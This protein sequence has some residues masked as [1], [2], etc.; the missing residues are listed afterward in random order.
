MSRFRGSF[1]RNVVVL[2]IVSLFT[3]V[4]S[5]MIYPIIFIFLQGIGASMAVVGLVEGVAEATASILKVVSGRHSD[6]KGKRKI[7]AL[8]GYSLSS[9]A[10]PLLFL[11]GS[12]QWVLGARFLDRFGKGIRTSPRDAL[13]AESTPLESRGAAFGLHRTLDTIGA[14]VGPL[15]ALALIY[16]LE[17]RYREI[18]L[19]SA[20]PAT[21]AVILLT[22]FVKE[23]PVKP[24]KNFKFNLKSLNPVYRRFLIVSFVFSLGNFTTA[25]P[26]LRARDIFEANHTQILRLTD[27]FPP[28]SDI[29]ALTL[30]I[31]VVYNITYAAAS[32]PAG[33]LSDRIGRKNIL[34]LGYLI[35]SA[36][37]LGFAFLSRG[38]S[39]WLLFAV[40]G[41]Y[42]G[43]TD[44][45]SKAFVVDLMP[46]VKATALGVYYTLTGLTMLAAGII[47]GL[48]WDFYG[49]DMAFLY[50]ST[51]S[52]LAAAMLAKIKIPQKMERRGRENLMQ[53]N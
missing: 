34:T 3:D 51:T 43:I 27:I 11:A 46:D 28:P 50:G 36:V 4:S 7:Y 32:T 1:S 10:K 47:G 40:Y 5:E 37:Y 23:N 38:W 6:Y 16:I 41:F 20:I 18:F 30:L 53:A 39:I 17:G 13:I 25:F 31:Y 2:G 29:V 33:V 35:F 48:I 15:L 22:V 12:W 19:L 14:I 24:V 21:L 26:L 9:L 52:L 8:A 42:I 44:G 45:V 49:A